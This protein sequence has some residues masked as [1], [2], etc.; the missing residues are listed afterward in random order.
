MNET[1]EALYSRYL[2]T[3]D[4]QVFRILLERHRETLML[5]ING[6]VNNLDDAEE[7]M[8]D[9]FAE[10]AAGPTL[11]SGRSAFKTWLFSIGKNLALMHL[12]K[13]RRRPVA[14]EELSEETPD[15]GEL[16]E[17]QLLKED[18][19]RQLYGA[20]QQLN[21]DYRQILILLYFE[22]M[23]HEEAARV[24]RKNRRQIYHLAERG[25]AALREKLERMGFSDAQYG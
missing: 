6:Y 7:L 8:M 5:F 12:R 3:H 20:L 1:D 24:M 15:P 17:L 9:A 2:T 19:N 16:P 25:R 23:S 13:Q 10:V 4:G 18:R 22:Q 11:F 14:S 21:D